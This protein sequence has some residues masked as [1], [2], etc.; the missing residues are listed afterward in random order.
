[1]PSGV[2]QG[3]PA[4]ERQDRRA[5]DIAEPPG[6]S[7]DL[8]VG[9]R[10][11]RDTV[12]SRHHSRDFAFAHAYYLRSRVLAL[13]IIFSLLSPLWILVDS[14][15]LPAE[16]LRYTLAGRVVLMLG[17]VGVLMVALFSRERIRRIRL[18][19]GM[20]LAL[21]AAFY[22]LVLVMLPS[23]EIHHLVG[24]G[25]IPFLLVASLSVF[26]F[27]ILESL[28]AGL[29]MLG[30]L[31]FSQLLDGSWMTGR[32]VEAF[33]LLSSLLVVSLAAN[34][35]QLSLLLRL[36]RQATHDPL[37]GLF[38]RG[39]LEVH[40]AKIQAWQ[41]EMEGGQAPDGVP[42]SVLM[43][44]LDH[45]KQINDTYGHSVGDAVLRQLAHILT[46]QTR[47]QDCAAR[48]GGE[49]FVV[50]LLGSDGI[51]AQEV[52]ERIRRAVEL[53]DFVDH[54]Q[55]PVSVTTSIGVTELV[56]NEPAEQALKRADEALYRAKHEGRNRIVYAELPS[57]A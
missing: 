42:C 53:H 43:I 19:A 50:I 16:L 20:L 24:Y 33:W 29:A 48:Y 9:L 3:S 1:M 34:H 55:R 47:K 22:V 36:Y 10:S 4:A 14:L 18:C 41:R 45:F 12:T 46:G 15:V 8:F 7:S 51:R 25:F 54:E 26:P 5:G 40:L 52:A 2:Q 35:F 23:G 56:L 39:A 57:Q 32:G 30:L 37:T 6:P 17:L 38:N 31:M 11:L 44:D 28:F 21:P 13:G 27:T 49:E